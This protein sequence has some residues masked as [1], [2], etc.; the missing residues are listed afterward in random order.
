ML[1]HYDPY[2]EAVRVETAV[3]AGSEDA[4]EQLATAQ[5]LAKENDFVAAQLLRAAGRAPRRD[6]PQGVGGRLGSDRR[7]LRARLHPPFVAGSSRR[8]HRRTR[9]L[10]CTPPPLPGSERHTG[11][12]GR[13]LL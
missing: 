8:G 9:A 11:I 4:E 1:R 5:R 6:R 12:L 2:L 7:P 13:G 10:G 3:V